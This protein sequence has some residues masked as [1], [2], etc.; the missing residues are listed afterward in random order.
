[1]VIV[2]VLL[3]SYLDSP[4]LMLCTHRSSTGSTSQ[5][6]PSTTICGG[7]DGGSFVIDFANVTAADA[8]LLTPEVS[9]SVAT[10][11]R[12]TLPA[13]TVTV[14]THNGEKH[15]SCSRKLALIKLAFAS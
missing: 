3:L 6:S 1:L 12:I 9:R 14:S 5:P 4:F 11:V 10:T 7:G 13:S 8:T 2:H 15:C